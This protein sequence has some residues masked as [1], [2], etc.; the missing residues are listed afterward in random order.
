VDRRRKL[1]A[2]AAVVVAVLA[3]VIVLGV[4]LTR[5][6]GGPDVTVPDEPAASVPTS[7]E[8]SQAARAPLTG[9]V[10][11]DDLRHPAVAIKVSDVQ[12]AHPQLGV[13]RA[14]IVF[15]EPIGVSYTRLLAV[16]HSDL[17]E[18]VG[19][20]RSVRPMD[21]PLL[22]PLA[23]VF[24]NT[25]GA[26]WVLEYVDSVA[27]VDNLGTLRVGGSG[28]YV[29]D[30]E[31]PRPDHVFAKPA[32]LLELTEFTAAPE[33][34]FD[35]APDGERSSAEL[36]GDRGTAVEVPYGPA[37]SVTWTYD[38][39][40]GR[41]LREQPW[42]AHTTA[43]GVQ[44]SAINVLV[45]DVAATTGKIGEGRGA[46]VP[47]LQLVDGSGDFV[48]LAGGQSVA[49]TWSKAGVDDPFVFRTDGGSELRLSQGNT[50]VELPTP[51]AAVTVR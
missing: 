42:G 15:A 19:P 46:P 1:G 47:I 11:E 48:A 6:G 36:A 3:G 18:L 10:T 23:P 44:V 45:L 43:D 21:A 9:L 39:A 33:P 22:S 2:A 28:A 30:A 31:R 26:E 14:D 40:T 25:M 50:W 35:Y 51:S 5:E 4:L 27:T 49:G 13:D 37:W 12:Q 41:Y 7:T 38:D 32:V 20:V 34:Y 24:G 29:L 17:P 16:F 8:P